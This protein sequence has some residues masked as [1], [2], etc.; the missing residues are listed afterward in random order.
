MQFEWP[1]FFSLFSVSDF[2]EA[3][4]TV[5]ELSALGW[6]IGMVLGFLLA[7]AKLSTSRWLRI[8]AAI[9]IWF[10][11]S[12][13]LLVLVVF[14][15][16]L[17]QLFP[18]TREVLSNPFY[19]GLFALIVTEAAYMAEIHRGGLI[20]VAKGQ[21]EAGRA[22]GV[23][24]I[25]LQRLVVIPQAFRISLPTLINE[26]ITVVKLTSLV[27]VISLTEILT[28]GQ[29]LYATNFLVMETLSAVA[30]YYV[31]IVTVFGWL[32]QR[33]EQYLE[34]N[35][36]TPQTLDEY[37]L[38]ALR[39]N[40]TAQPSLVRSHVGPGAAPALQLNNIH[41]SYGQHDVLQGIDL[42][43][44]AGQVISIIG[45]S[46]SGKTSL[47]RT[48]NGLESIDQG[49]IILFGESFIHAGD[50]PNSLQIRQGVQ[51]IGMVFQNFNLFPHR[52]ILDNI[53]LAPRYHG[54]DRD[55]S[56]QRAYAL[57]DKVGL[58]AHAHKYPHQLS[59][60][61]QQRVAIARA[62]AMDPQI[63]LFDEPTSALDP[64]LVGDVLNV[65]RDL[66]KEGMTM[67][68]VTHE[69]EFAMSISDR[70]IFMEDGNIQ[71]DA[72]PQVIRA[73]DA[74]DRVR[75]FMGLVH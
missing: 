28:V 22:L 61:Q 24:L 5:I 16:N 42:D 26:Y 62:L 34:M 68:I 1:Y 47:I 23:G 32:L 39:G 44:R 17:P 50:N 46:G 33:F 58:L 72:A 37:G 29:R 35:N 74:G 75:R 14:V 31:L 12:V 56:E 6:F 36:R 9:Y 38:S 8:P 27:S 53:T 65:I 66:A 52:T 4:I 45:P 64:E 13:P 18:V 43:V 40:L 15:Y 2:W 54:Q 25:G 49:E 67:L 21:K 48:I 71:V 55:E 70:V 57:L 10:F 11:R 20:S 73:H 19:S 51:R 59:G 60:G 63:M 41:K 30:V 69:M 7:S 3:C